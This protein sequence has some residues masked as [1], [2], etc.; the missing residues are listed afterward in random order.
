MCRQ[1]LL[2]PFWFPNVSEPGDCLRVFAHF[3]LVEFGYSAAPKIVIMVK[4]PDLRLE[5][6]EFQCR[7]EIFAHIANFYFLWK[8]ARGHSAVLVGIDLVLRTD[9][10]DFHALRLIRLQ[11]LHEIIR[12][13]AEVV[14]ADGAAEHGIVIL[15]PARW[16]P[17]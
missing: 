4:E 7:S 15:H 10:I 3:R 13:G 17:R 1:N 9:G 12:V 2:D 11:E 5:A 6:G 8:E 14:R 16:T